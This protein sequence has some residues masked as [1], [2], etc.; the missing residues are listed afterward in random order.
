MLIPQMWLFS[1][2]CHFAM[3][4]LIFTADRDILRLL[5][6]SH[7]ILQDSLSTKIARQFIV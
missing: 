2:L 7:Y 1:E 3:T 4:W 6:K 5:L